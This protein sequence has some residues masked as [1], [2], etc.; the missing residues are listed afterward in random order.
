VSHDED[1]EI[2]SENHSAYM[3]RVL[4]LL[5]IFSCLVS[6]NGYKSIISSDI[7]LPVHKKP[8][9]YWKQLINETN[10]TIFS[11][12]E[13][14]K[15]TISEQVLTYNGQRIPL[16]EPRAEFE[17]EFCSRLPLLSSILTGTI[18]FCAV[19]N[20]ESVEWDNVT[21]SHEDWSN[22]LAYGRM[23]IVGV[24]VVEC[25]AVTRKNEEVYI[26]PY[27][28]LSANK[29][30]SACDGIVLAEA[31]EKLQKYVENIF[32]TRSA[33]TNLKYYTSR[34]ELQGRKV[35]LMTEKGISTL[36]DKLIQL[37]FEN[38]LY[39]FFTKLFFNAKIWRHMSL[40][41]KES[42]QPQQLNL[43]L[44]TIFLLLITLC[45]CACLILI[46][47]LILHAGNK[48]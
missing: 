20:I 17:R 46:F 21:F 19:N 8:L 1:L 27:N 5:W 48:Y 25:S 3:A 47:E 45:M 33:A 22:I 26:N 36:V 13:H 9:K 42:L 10:F 41:S 39:S 11:L 2:S 16:H 29:L 32:P 38:G 15:L 23:D 12:L 7:V 40:R 35:I 4:F 18:P 44:A 31:T 14:P 34:D 24:K 30:L 28:F 43:N 6:S 37:A